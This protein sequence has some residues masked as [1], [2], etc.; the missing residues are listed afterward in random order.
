MER[1]MANHLSLDKKI[2]ILNALVEGN[3]ICSIVRMLNVHKGAILRLL[4]EVGNEAKEILDREIV[5]VNARFVQCDEIWCY[6]GKKQKQCNEEE[7]QIGEVGDQYIFVA[8]DSDSKLVVSHLIGK[9]TI[10]NARSIMKDLSY[11]I[12]QRFQLS[13][14]AFS[15]YY[16]AVDSVFGIDI[17]YGMIHKKYAEDYA[18]EKRYS[19]AHIVSVSLATITGNPIKTRI[20]TSHIERQNL[21]MRMNMRRLTRL[22][23]A[24]SKKLVNLKAAV[25]LHFFY[26][27]FMRIHQTLRITPAMQAGITNHIWGWGEF[28]GINRK[29]R[30][31]A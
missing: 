13:T 26:Y 30:L 15:G 20:S 18:G 24:F 10:E 22:T 4:C 21:T 17:D 12:P 28:L 27:N 25:A 1:I 9:R 5:N 7:K 6:V 2:A 29:K 11:R 3:S 14:D 23:N 31:A 8:M 19:P 16:E